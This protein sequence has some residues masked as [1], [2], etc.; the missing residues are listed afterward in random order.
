MHTRIDQLALDYNMSKSMADRLLK[1]RD[2]EIVIVID[3]SGSM[4]TTVDGTET[5]RW[6]ELCK[7][8]KIV[9]EI[10]VIFDTNGVD[11][12]FIN[13]RTFEKVKDP[14]VVDEAFTIPPS[15]YTPLVPVLD[16]IFQSPLSQSGRDKKLLVFV[17]SDGVPTDD[18]GEP[19]VSELERIMCEKR[20]I[21]TTHVSF[22]LCT[23]DPY[24]VEYLSEWDKVMPNIDVTDDFKTE[25]AKVR[26]YR[27]QDF[28]FTF[29]DYVVKVLVGAIDREIDLLNE[30][31]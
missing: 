19:V 1:L 28:P 4:Q 17:A 6:Q 16:K 8:I 5:T 22:L 30:P 10:A 12:Y 31:I 20:K 2:F 11:I 29:G 23:D 15:G 13:G 7:L 21:S 24:C 26:R 18:D 27:G 9:I 3:D 25:T 14:R